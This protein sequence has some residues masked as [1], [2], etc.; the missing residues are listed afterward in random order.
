M[1]TVILSEPGRFT[2]GSEGHPI[3]G[4]GQALVRVHSIGVC[5]TDIKAYAGAQPFFTYPRILGHELGVEVLEAP[6]GQTRI[7]N[8]EHCAVEP[9]QACGH[10]HPC[11]NGRANCCE[12][13]RVLGVHRDGGMRPLMCVPA[14][15]LFPSSKL[16]PDPA[17][18]G[19]NLGDWGPRGRTLRSWR[20]PIGPNSR[21][22]TD[23]TDRVA[24]CGLRWRRCHSARTFQTAAAIRPAVSG[25]GIGATR[26][27]QI[28][29][30]F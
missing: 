14:E 10:C 19:G 27:G 4:P 11:R 1:R 17:G 18:A 24:I 12:D 20:Q 3:P 16:S 30:G 8:G 23:R 6:S 15:M 13:L 9:Y 22:R 7:Q 29:S 25:P 21:W 28:R 26:R 2:I 5:G